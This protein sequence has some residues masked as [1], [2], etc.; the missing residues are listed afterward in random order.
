MACLQVDLVALLTSRLDASVQQLREDLTETREQQ[1]VRWGHNGNYNLITD[2]PRFQEIEQQL[3]NDNTNLSQ[4]IQLCQQ[5]NTN[6]RSLL[7]AQGEE[8]TS[9]A[10]SHKLLTGIIILLLNLTI[11]WSLQIT[12]GC[13]NQSLSK[14]KRK[15][16]TYLITLPR[17]AAK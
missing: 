15:T 6:Q 11:I 4:Q 8:H 9:L 5:E 7:E 12:L 1:L 3:I 10:E 14:Q 16:V 2:L 17:Y 13:W